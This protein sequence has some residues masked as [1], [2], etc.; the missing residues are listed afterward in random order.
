[1]MMM[2]HSGMTA[3]GEPRNVLNGLI[4]RPLLRDRT[5]EDRVHRVVQGAV[6][7][8][9][10][11]NPSDGKEKIVELRFINQC[12]TRYGRDV[13][14]SLRT[15]VNNLKREQQLYQPEEYLNRLR[16]KDRRQFHTPAGTVGPLER[17][18]INATNAG[19]NFDAWVV[20]FYGEWSDK[21]TKLPQ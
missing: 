4:P 14:T 2:Q 13:A 21:L 19:E 20:G 12:Q 8:V 18:I 11:T 17:G 15:A 3:K 1:V 9:A 6:P 7:D 10:Y 5:Q 16:L